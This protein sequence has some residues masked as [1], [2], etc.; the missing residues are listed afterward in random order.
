MR[1][2]LGQCRLY[3]FRLTA[4]LM[5]L[6]VSVAGYG[7]SARLTASVS[8]NPVGTGEQF[9]VVFS[10]SGNIESFSPPDFRGFAVLGGPNQS[11]SFSSINGRVTSSM[12]ISYVLMARQV[13]N[14][15]IGA[16]TMVSDGK[17]YQSSPL[18]V[19]V[20]KGQSVPQPAPGA[21]GRAQEPVGEASDEDLSKRLF[22]R[23]VADKTNVYQ[24]EQITVS[25]KLYTNIEL[26]DNQPGKMPDFNGF[27]S[28]EV[29]NNDP[30]VRWVVENHNGRRYH[31]AVLR[32]IVLFPERSGKL[33]L[34]PMEMDF[35]VRQQVPSNDPFEQFFGG[36]HRDVKYKVKSLPVS[37]QVKP[38]PEAGKPEGFQGAVGKFTIHTVLDKQAVKANEALNYTFKV[39]G[40]GNLK[41]LRAPE[42]TLAPEIEKYDPKVSDNIDIS[43]NGVSGA[44]EFSYLLIPR[45]QGDFT[46][47]APQFSYFNPETRKYVTLTGTA[48]PVTVAKGDPGSGIT[49]FGPDGKEDVRLLSKDIAYI[50]TGDVKLKRGNEGFYGSFG[51]YALLAL[52]P[53]AFI[54]A[55]FY[56]RADR[57]RN[58]DLV[59]VKSRKANKLA[60]K[61]LANAR[62]Q[63]QEGNRS[64]FYEAVY[65]G[66]YG[67]LSDKLNIPYAELN[68]E[69]ISQALS[70]RG[71]DESLIARL[72]ATLEQ[73][74]MARY[75]PVTAV[76]D[77]EMLD[78]AQD[79][80]T[81]I[82][83][84]A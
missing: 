59:V 35:L 43:A 39:T 78:K 74:E 31:V 41:L 79:V 60:A 16:A 22:M 19:R 4:V 26:V 55:I 57:E 12:S 40:S 47:D 10:T 58:R 80:I 17:K 32:Q 18:K 23:A 64:A 33:T 63:M 37:I 54:A 6:I 48:F 3:M 56:R 5:L 28:Q 81:E 75:A 27:W 76:T 73:C 7:Q 77:Q 53:L 70:A 84:K 52:G 15:T 51:F 29:K 83:H 68:R 82:E 13:G 21:Q 45:H 11:S 42:L 44:R 69:N 36:A 20:V 46:I 24:G 2:C 38:L 14:F 9:E 71:L 34:D 50:R 8:S 1:G 30:N 65:R 49:A 72:D 61:H 25:Y 62:K 67:Y 66:L